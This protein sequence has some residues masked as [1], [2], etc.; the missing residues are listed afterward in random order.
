MDNVTGSAK[1]W[2]KDSNEVDKK[3]IKEKE[4]SLKKKKKIIVDLTK[5]IDA[6]KK[7]KERLEAKY[8][9]L[10]EKNLY[11]SIIHLE[12]MIRSAEKTVL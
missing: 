8:E 7:L 11:D 2:G 9:I 1:N 12:S 3:I 5:D 6:A 10:P 4:V